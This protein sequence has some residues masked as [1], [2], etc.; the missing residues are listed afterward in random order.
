MET[1]ETDFNELNKLIA[2][3]SSSSGKHIQVIEGDKNKKQTIVKGKS[4]W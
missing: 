3:S 4:P 2:R 1:F